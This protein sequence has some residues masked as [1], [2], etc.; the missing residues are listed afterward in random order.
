MERALPAPSV[1]LTRSK[2]D[3]VRRNT[4]LAAVAGANAY[5]ISLWDLGYLP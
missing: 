4:M 3:D 1:S 2:E 5:E